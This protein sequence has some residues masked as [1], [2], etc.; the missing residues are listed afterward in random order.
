[1]IAQFWIGEYANYD[2]RFQAEAASSILN[3]VG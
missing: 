2:Q 1:M 3:K